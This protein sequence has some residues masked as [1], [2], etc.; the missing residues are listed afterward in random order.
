MITITNLTWSNWFS[1]GEDNFID[2]E[3]PVLQIMGKNGTGKTSIPLIL[4]EVFYGKNCKGKKKASLV[5]RYLN[6]PTLKATCY[7]SDDYGNEYKIDLIRKTTL[8]LSLFKNGKDISSH[9]TTGTYKT[10][11]DIIGLDFKTFSQLIYQSSTDKLEFLTATDANRKKFLTT[12]FA[13]D[14]YIIINE[15]FKKVAAKLNL[16][17]AGITSKITTIESWVK[18]HEKMDFSIRDIQELP[19]INDDDINKIGELRTSLNNITETNKRI[20]KNNQYKE[21]LNTIDTS[22]LSDNTLTVDKT[23]KEILIKEGKEVKEDLI[24]HE[25]KLK[26]LNSTKSKI[27]ALGDKC[28][29]CRQDIPS[30]LKDSMLSEVIEEE[31][32]L[33]DLCIELNDT[34][35]ALRTSLEYIQGK[36][37]KIRERDKISSEVARLSSSL[38]NSLPKDVLDENELKSSLSEISNRIDK[39]KKEIEAISRNNRAAAA[40]NSRVEV[41]SEQLEEHR[42]EIKGLEDSS[43]QLSDILNKVELIKKAFSPSGLLSYKIDYLVKDLEKEI[44][45]YLGTLSGG[46]FQL[47]FKLENEKLNVEIIDEGMSVGIEELSAGELARINAATLLA[48]RKLMAAISSTKINILFLDEIMGVLDENGKEMLIEVL[49]EETDLNT[50]LVSHEYSHPL[51]PKVT[52]VKDKRISKIESE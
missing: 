14:K 16:E 52:V 38:D 32:S 26:M 36:E 40:H 25:T 51:I 23:K 46:K 48:I 24:R 1:Y 7:F 19:E 43:D 5:N 29:S 47:L 31:E 42:T 27:N 44:N 22:I 3:Q 6:K 11:Q 12:L 17:L 37:K 28:H 13:L 15:Q 35:I 34:L 49:H 18:T 39:V 41:V 8:K 20:N 50:L 9:T 10:I 2:F 30:D 45:E 4:Q 33:N 21:L